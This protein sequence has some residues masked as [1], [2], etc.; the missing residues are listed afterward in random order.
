[1]SVQV[2]PRV[3]MKPFCS[4]LLRTAAL[5]FPNAARPIRT[6]C[7]SLNHFLHLCSMLGE[8][9]HR[10]SIWQV[11]GQFHAALPR[12]GWVAAIHG[13]LRQAIQRQIPGNQPI[14][15]DR[16]HKIPKFL[17]GF[18][19]SKIP[20]RVAIGSP[21]E[22]LCSY[23]LA[24]KTKALLSTTIFESSL[25]RFAG[26]RSGLALRLRK[27][28]LFTGVRFMKQSTATNQTIPTHP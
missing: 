22:F 7:P 14:F 12:N 25:L 13:A 9:S 24:R 16:E 1:M 28:C 26:T 6:N 27:R 15:L 20:V 5:A 11:L 8:L 18:A 19:V 10:I 21:M 3:R 23:Y 17:D 4:P 2:I